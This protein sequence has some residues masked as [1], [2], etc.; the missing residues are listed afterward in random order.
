MA[1]KSA[2]LTTTVVDPM[3]FIPEGTVD[4]VHG[5]NTVQGKGAPK[6]GT[7]GGFYSSVDAANQTTLPTPFIVG[8]VEQTLHRGEGGL[9]LVDITVEVAD[10]DGVT[11]YELRVTKI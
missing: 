2:A 1:E 6:D 9:N 11:N 3:F 8:V 5:E 4:I 10:Q 7:A